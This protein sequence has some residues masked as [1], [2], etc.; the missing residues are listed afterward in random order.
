LDEDSHA[1]SA[2]EVCIPCKVDVTKRKLSPSF[3][4]ALANTELA[5]SSH[6]AAAFTKLLPSA[7]CAAATAEDKLAVTHCLQTKCSSI[8]PV[9]WEDE[10]KYNLSNIM[11]W[12]AWLTFKSTSEIESRPL[13][14]GAELIIV[15]P[16][17]SWYVKS[18]KHVTMVMHFLKMEEAN[19]NKLQKDANGRI[20]PAYCEYTSE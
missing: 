15:P 19:S 1:L 16:L 18:E 11:K 17:L 20:S 5:P 2:E 3:F 14:C 13:K 6:F 4:K 9:N 7:F 12:C 8:A 10:S